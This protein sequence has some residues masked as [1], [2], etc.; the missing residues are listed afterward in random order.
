MKSV[1]NDKHFFFTLFFHRIGKSIIH[2]GK[3]NHYVV[4][5]KSTRILRLFYKMPITPL[6]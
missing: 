4:I 2:L 5:R 6:N 3:I 1:I